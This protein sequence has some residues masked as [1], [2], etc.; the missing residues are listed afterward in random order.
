MIYSTAS[1]RYVII[2]IATF[3]VVYFIGYTLSGSNVG[4]RL[5]NAIVRYTGMQR[6]AKPQLIADLAYQP[7]SSENWELKYQL[8]N[9]QLKRSN[10][11]TAAEQEGHSAKTFFQIY[12]EPTFSCSFATRVGN[13]GD[14]GKWVCNPQQIKQAAE[15]QG[16]KVIVYSLGSFDKVYI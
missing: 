8:R 7:D 13:T 9:W 11:P 5:T 10:Q 12:W 15:L 1:A 14:G 16:R 2:A 6:V 3:V 4:P